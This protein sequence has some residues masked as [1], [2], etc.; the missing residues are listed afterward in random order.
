MYIISF[1]FDLASSV[2]II[3][4]TVRREPDITLSSLFV[5]AAVNSTEYSRESLVEYDYDDI[6]YPIPFNELVEKKEN[7]YEDFNKIR[8][9]FPS[10]IRYGSVEPSLN[11]DN[12]FAIVTGASDNHASCL[13]NVLYSSLL[14]SPYSL[15]I[16]VDYGISNS[17]L[18]ILLSNVSRLHS[19]RHSLGSE[20]PIYYRKYNFAHFPAWSN[21]NEPHSKGGY[22]WKVITLFDILTEYKGVVM[23]TDAGSILGNSEIDVSRARVNGF[24]SSVAGH[25][26]GK[27][28]HSGTYQCI[29]DMKWASNVNSV[30]NKTC[31]SGGY[32]IID[33][34]NHTVMANVMY[35]FIK[36]SLTK[37]CITPL[38]SS[39][40]NH[41]Q[42]Q[43]V[44]SILVQSLGVSQACDSRYPT[45]VRFHQD[46][47]S[48]GYRIDTNRRFIQELTTKYNIT[49]TLVFCFVCWTRQSSNKGTL[50]IISLRFHLI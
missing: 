20:A 27:W 7:R 35:P 6:V 23:W 37:R 13:I 2:Q 18:N 34:W 29:E 1:L 33:Y 4:V 5:N 49:W 8:E 48:H 11:V 39:R 12:E 47:E 44:L 38:G 24:Y 19:I 25:S 15:L 41:R 28:T 45:Y 32:M 31:C 22:A 36:C 17:K 10:F 30:V 46:Y 9:G 3:S 21:I 26:I 42:D 40:R 50:I 43:S 16:I 14:T